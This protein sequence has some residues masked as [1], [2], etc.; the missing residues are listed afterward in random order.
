MYM[1]YCKKS[2][3]TNRSTIGEKIGWFRNCF[4]LGSVP[5]YVSTHT[6]I[7]YA[8]TLKG[9][10]HDLDIVCDQ[11]WNT[12]SSYCSRG[13]KHVC[14]VAWKSS[15]IYCIV[16]ERGATVVAKSSGTSPNIAILALV[17]PIA[18]VSSNPTSR[19]VRQRKNLLRN[20]VAVLFRNREA[21]MR[22]GQTFRTQ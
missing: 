8:T 15:L 18:A 19:S 6:T 10:S 16:Y 9:T 11:I 22:I 1:T 5:L 20:P 14:F 4:D 13:F 3:E 12:G 17:S 2:S 7:S 21:T